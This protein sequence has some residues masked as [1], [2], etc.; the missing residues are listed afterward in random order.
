MIRVNYEK[1]RA[2]ARRLSSAATVCDNVTTSANRIK[3]SVPSYWQGASATAF[4]EELSDWM[5]ENK[6]IRSELTALSADIIRIARELEEAETRIAAE[7]AKLAASKV[8]DG[9][10][11][12]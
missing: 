3:A 6:A 4:S 5:R 7:A 2:A 1:T 9:G 11:S 10:G 8:H 12:R